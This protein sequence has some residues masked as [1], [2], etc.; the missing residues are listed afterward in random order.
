MDRTGLITLYHGTSKKRAKKILREGLKP[1]RK[2]GRTYFFDN[3]RDALD[4]SGEAAVG[5]T[6]PRSLAKLEY[7]GGVPSTVGRRL[8][9]ENPEWVVK[10]RIPSSRVI[11]L[12]E[13]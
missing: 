10:G 8:A 3:L 6:L 4:W 9:L 5:V 1:S 12:Y 11:G 13:G 7:E 2:G